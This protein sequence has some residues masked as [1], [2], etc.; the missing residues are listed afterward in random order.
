MKNLKNQ[1]GCFFLT[2]GVVKKRTGEVYVSSCGRTERLDE[3]GKERDFFFSAAAHLISTGPTEENTVSFFFSPLNK[4]KKKPL[5]RKRRR[6]KES[7][8]IEVARPK[9]HLH[10]PLC[11][12]FPCP[13]FPDDCRPPFFPVAALLRL[14]GCTLRVALL[15]ACKSA[16]S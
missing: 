2:Y 11:I 7:V 1:S 12:S 13:E 4:A 9:D 8:V 5:T 14:F 6:K 15:I 3:S 16:I 10:A